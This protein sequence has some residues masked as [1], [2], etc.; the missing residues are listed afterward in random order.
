MDKV[1]ID[2]WLWAARFFKTRSQAASAVTG[3]KVH[4]NDH[5]VKAAHPVKT[6]D[7]LE[8]TKGAYEFVVMIEALAE[9]RGSAKQAQELYTETE[10]SIARREQISADRKLALQSYQPSRRKPSKKERQDIRK[11]KYQ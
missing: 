6:G 7:Q 11:L 8:I 3:G 5:R 2:K 1:R 4:V 9:R 10:E